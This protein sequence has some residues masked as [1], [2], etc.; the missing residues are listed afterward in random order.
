VVIDAI[1]ASHA[2][3]RPSRT[4][5]IPA[6][7]DPVRAIRS[8]RSPR[9]PLGRC[10]ARRRRGWAAEVRAAGSGSTAAQAAAVGQDQRRDHPGGPRTRRSDD[11]DLNEAGR[12]P[13]DRASQGAR[14]RVW[15]FD[16]TGASSP[17]AGLEQ[18][19][20]SPV[21]SALPT[22][23]IHDGPARV[24]T[25]APPE[26]HLR[27]ERGGLPERAD[28]GEGRLCPAREPEVGA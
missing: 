21:T 18:P 9:A 14:G 10:G 28:A 22:R 8:V 26:T 1:I 5:A 16:A 23:V 7:A 19:R 17:P 20:W 6:D 2:R 15:M 4:P 11:R 24:L 12:R 3:A 13:R 25:A 27:P